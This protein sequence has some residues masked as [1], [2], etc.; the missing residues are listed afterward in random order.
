[1]EGWQQ[2]FARDRGAIGKR[3]RVNGVPCTVVAVMPRVFDWPEGTSLWQ[4]APEP[5]PPSPLEVKDP[6]TNRDAHYFEAVARLKPGVPLQAAQQDL[7]AVATTLAREFPATDASA[8]IDLV[9]IRVDLTGDVRAALLLIQGAVALVLLI[10]CANV[11][12]LLIVRAT[13]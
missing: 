5:V 3:V 10:A 4:L 9:P 13:T 11:S 7:H 8:D 12:S 6:L 1:D 2:L